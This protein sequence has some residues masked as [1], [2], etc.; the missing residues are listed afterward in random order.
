MFLKFNTWYSRQLT[1]VPFRILEMKKTIF[2]L[3][4][5]VYSASPIT[6]QVERYASIITGTES[7]GQ[8]SIP[9]QNNPGNFPSYWALGF[10]P[11]ID[12]NIYKR[13]YLGIQFE[14]T[15]GEVENVKIRPLKGAGIRLKHFFKN[16]NPNRFLR[17]RFM[18]YAEMSWNLL[19]YTIDYQKEN[20]VEYFNK[21]SN[22]NVQGL[23]GVNFRLFK[24]FYLDYALRSMYYSKNE[25][26]LLANRVGLQ[27]HFGEKRKFSPRNKQIEKKL[28]HIISEKEDKLKLFD[29]RY[30]LKRTTLEGRYS[31]IFDPYD[32]GDIF[33]YKQNT[34]SVALITSISSDIYFG[35]MYQ[36]IWSS[37]RNQAVQHYY[38]VGPFIQY[39]FLRDPN[40]RRMFAE[41]GFF[42]GNIC[43]CG[44]SLSYKKENISFIP[45]GFGYEDRI[46]RTNWYWG[47]SFHIYRI[48]GN[49]SEDPETYGYPTIGISYK[50]TKDL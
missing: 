34:L 24:Y 8:F 46:N 48:L 14:Y 25:K 13:S 41:F 32:T 11:H 38:R 20:G 26:L 45:I 39:D 1:T 27:Y 18:P 17:D 6:A 9:S 7:S 33:Y 4:L 35:L 47:M 5:L 30:F 28:D 42:K 15:F 3:L 31:F 22:H 43:T 40:N 49:S 29:F 2:F 16:N 37:V 21:F 44:E 23:L 12:F 19:N 10:A 36:P 50:L